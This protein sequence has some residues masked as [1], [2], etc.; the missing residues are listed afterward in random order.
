[1]CWMGNHR[2][3]FVAV[4]HMEGRIVVAEVLAASSVVDILAGFGLAQS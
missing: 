2:M 4:H 1:M 3:G